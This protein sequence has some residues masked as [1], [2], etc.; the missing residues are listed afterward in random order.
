[1]AAEKMTAKEFAASLGISID[2]L[3]EHCKTA[4]MRIKESDQLVSPAQQQKIKT[5][6]VEQPKIEIKKNEKISMTKQTENKPVNKTDT[7]AEPVEAAENAPKKITL[8]RKTVSELKVTSAQGDQKT[9]SVKVVKKRTYVKRST[10]ASEENKVVEAEVPAEE[11]VI[12]V[13]Q[14]VVEEPVKVEEVQPVIA[15]EK[16]AAESTL[17]T[18]H[19]DKKKH[20]AHEEIEVLSEEEQEERKRK[21]KVKPGREDDKSK[22]RKVDLRRI[23]L[24]DEV[25]DEVPGIAFDYEPAALPPPRFIS[26]KHVYKTK[27]KQVFE[28][29]TKPIIY[30]VNIPENIKIADLAQKMSIKA[31]EIIKVLMKMGTMASIN[32]MI[33]QETAAL[34]VEELGHK[35]ILMKEAAIEETMHE[36]MEMSAPLEPRPPVVTIM[37][38]VDHGKTT[39]LDHIRRTRVAASEAGGITQN[40]GAYHVETPKGVITFLDTP[41]HEAFTAMRARGA[42]ATDIVVLVVAADDGVMPQTIEAISHAR[43]ANVPIVVAVNKMDKPEAQPDRVKTELSNH[44]VISE[45]WGGDVMFANISAKAGTGVDELLDAILLQAEVLELKARRQGPAEGLVVEAR[46]DKGRGVVATVLVQQGTLK[47]GDIVLAGQQF[48]RIRAM[49]DEKG[50]RVDEA[51]PSIPVEILGL[52]DI[53]QA[54]DEMNVVATERKAREIAMFRQSKSR[55]EKMAKQQAAKLENIFDRMG[56]GEVSSLN[57]VLKADVQGSVEALAD[58]LE[59]LSNN[60]VKVNIIVR[61]VGGITGS[62]A[63]LALASNAIIIGFNVRADAVAKDIIDNEKLDVHYH[64]IIYDVID[65]VKR[66]LTGMLAPEFKEEIIGLAEVRDV[67]R[68]SKFGSIAGCMV[69]DG[70]IKRNKPIRVL[71]DN[72]VIFEGELESLRR[73]K[74][75]VNEV[76]KGMECGIGVKNYHDIKPGDQV[77]IFDS[78]RVER[79]L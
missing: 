22:Q 32:Q 56:Q 73:F 43:A 58:S 63:N 16:Q 51:G 68:S 21:K 49:L 17:E 76:K 47:H 71:R 29:P 52:S 53:P 42:K 28:K 69:I 44:N 7:I 70:V 27:H 54:G 72:V 75:D 46:L 2:E 59:K 79:T 33:D 64:S 55:E 62:D 5:L 48:G 20:K 14:P 77:E 74:D 18:A 13:T 25:E 38:H 35:P 10:L 3:L 24:E 67:F 78:V 41:G 36:G 40:I 12:E 66:A 11:P 6:L 23:P 60:E 50:K 9:V 26:H 57:I 61:G 34:I 65:E 30:D 1:M 45:D 8:R 19:E 15:E 4:N 37:G 39:L 31:A